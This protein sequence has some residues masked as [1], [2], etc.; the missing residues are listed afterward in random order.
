MLRAVCLILAAL[1]SSAPV[2]AAAPASAPVPGR[3]PGPV[4]SLPIPR[5]VSLKRNEVNMRRGPGDDHPIVWKYV[6]RNMPVEI[7]NEYD[8]WRQVRDM[9]GQVGWISAN[10]LS[11]EPRFV[12]VRT[13]NGKALNP[14]PT[15]N[16][17]AGWPMRRRPD[18]KAKTVAIVEPGVVAEIRHCPDEWCEIKA[19]G[20]TGWIERVA[21]WGVYPDEKV[22]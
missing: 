7:T 4:T 11:G 19:G 17:E 12:V 22:K 3:T 8:L 6:R 1:L 9:D 15:N 13:K 21:L 10:M 14:A 20:T 18:M 2:M 16:P 5:F